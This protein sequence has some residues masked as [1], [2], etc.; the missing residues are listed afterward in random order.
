M[1]R[2]EKKAYLSRYRLAGREVRRLEEELGRWESRAASVTPGY[3]GEPGGSPRGDAL[4]QAVERILELR[5]DLG[6][7]LMAEVSLR[8]E[9]GAAIGSLEDPKLRLLLRLRYLDG[10]TW[11]EL[12]EKMDLDPRWVRRLHVRALDRLT[13][14]SPPSQVV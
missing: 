4:Q 11:D 6:R 9:M 2:E 3:G 1:T 7:Q 12:A 14:E 10:L 8:R 13:L 5:E